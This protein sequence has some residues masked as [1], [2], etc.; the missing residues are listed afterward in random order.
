[1]RSKR[2]QELTALKRSLEENEAAH[3]AA[4]GQLRQ[5]SS[6][7]VEELQEQLDSVKKVMSGCMS[8]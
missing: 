2:E 6:Q 1:M 7:V 3:E 4:M 8:K 5:K